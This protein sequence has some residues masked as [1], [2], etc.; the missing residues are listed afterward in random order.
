M[1][2]NTKFTLKHNIFDKL[3]DD[4]KKIYRGQELRLKS[5]I[6]L[7]WTKDDLIRIPFSKKI[8]WNDIIVSLG[9]MKVDL[10]SLKTDPFKEQKKIDKAT[11]ENHCS[12]ELIYGMDE[13][14]PIAL[15]YSDHEFEKTM[16]LIFENGK[17]QQLSICKDCGEEDWKN[18]QSITI[19]KTEPEEKEEPKEKLKLD[20]SVTSC[21]KDKTSF[22]FKQ[23]V[24]FK[25]GQEMVALY[26]E[27]HNL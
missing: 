7:G 22:V 13:N 21:D 9:G 15:S 10:K 23:D 4:M 16:D 12:Y 20:H 25:V 8:E 11:K 17:L 26:N 18:V 14:R 19:N 1:N 3:N 2:S 24:P 5:W 27:K 6:N